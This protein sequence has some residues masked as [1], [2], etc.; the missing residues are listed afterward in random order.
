MRLH[1]GVIFLAGLTSE[2]AIPGESNTLDRNSA[3]LR[4]VL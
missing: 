1:Y 2:N 3:L 4:A